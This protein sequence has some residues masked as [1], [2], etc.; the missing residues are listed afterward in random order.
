MSSMSSLALSWEEALENISEADSDAVDAGPLTTNELISIRQFLHR[1][2]APPVSLLIQEAR[3][4]CE[5]EF[6]FYHAV[7]AA[8]ME[9]FP[10]LITRRTKTVAVNLHKAVLDED[11]LDNLY[12]DEASG[13]SSHRGENRE[14]NQQ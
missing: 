4:C 14:E 6:A 5:T 13:T 7:A 2:S 9:W 1:T 10:V 12:L 8:I 3:Q 11:L